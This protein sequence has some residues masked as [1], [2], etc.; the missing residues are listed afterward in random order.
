MQIGKLLF[1]P[2]EKDYNAVAPQIKEA[3]TGRDYA[4]DVFVASINPELADTDFFCKEY[5]VAHAISTNCLVV[6]AR[7]ADKKW[8]AAWLILATDMA[9]I[10]G[11]VRRQLDARKISF[12]PMDTALELTKMEYGGITPIGLPESWTILVDKSVMNNDVVVIGG[13]TRGSKLAIN[14]K[15][16]PEL[17]NTKILPITK[18]KQLL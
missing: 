12:A 14:T 10:N 16:F 18:Q 13:G 6:E 9:D 17:P 2:I 7:R 1:Y 5:D 11:V 4:K 3:L 15:I 8:Y